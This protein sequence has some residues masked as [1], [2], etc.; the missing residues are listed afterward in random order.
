[1]PMNCLI[2]FDD[3]REAPAAKAYVKRLRDNGHRCQFRNGRIFI[4]EPVIERGDPPFDTILVSASVAAVADVYRRW[5]AN[6]NC[7]YRGT[8][9]VINLDDAVPVT[10][11]EEVLLDQAGGEVLAEPAPTPEPPPL[12]LE[13]VDYLAKP[14]HELREAVGKL[15]GTKPKN[16]KEATAALKLLDLL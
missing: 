11:V 10:P 1:M 12:P 7:T 5:F 13:R 4:F 14:W 16:K 3:G 15:T 6:E 8:V 9:E 2:Y